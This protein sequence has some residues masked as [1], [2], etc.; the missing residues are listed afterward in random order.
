MKTIK[1]RFS[2]IIALAGVAII[3]ALYLSV[4]AYHYKVAAAIAGS[5]FCDLSNVASCS[6]VLQSS[7]SKVFGI[8]FPWIA[9][10]VY[11]IILV[12]A[13]W[14]VTHQMARTPAKLIMGLSG[15]G[16]LFNF[17]IMYREIALIHAFC[18]LCFICT[19]IIISIFAISSTIVR[20]QNMPLL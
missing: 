20:K 5:S 11:P 1:T 16:M 9:L 10:V 7:Y 3:N 8:P 19:I 14:G 2:V 17:F 12:I 4:K 18:L 15:A 13:I 6:L